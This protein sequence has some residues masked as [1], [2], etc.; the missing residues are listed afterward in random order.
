LRVRFSK[1]LHP[2]NKIIDL[3]GR[4][5]GYLV[6]I[7]F[8]KTEHGQARW[9][10]KCDCGQVKS[11]F[12]HSLRKGLSKSCGCRTAE[13]QGKMLIRHGHSIHHQHT[14]E[15]ETWLSMKKRCLNPKN[16]SYKDYGGRGIRICAR[17]MN[18]FENF[19]ADM[20]PR[21]SPQHS[22]DRINNDGDYEPSNCRWASPKEQANNR[23]KRI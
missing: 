10:C 4:R 1:R 19:L 22:L 3:T 2:V 23:R 13:L 14:P 18:S 20:G 7:R 11:I 21:P 17:W 12:G 8:E 5:F 15:Y 9:L 16:K 6:A